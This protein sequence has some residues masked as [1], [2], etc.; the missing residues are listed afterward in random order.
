MIL[1]EKT[2]ETLRSAFEFLLRMDFD[3]SQQRNGVGLNKYDSKIIHD[4]YDEIHEITDELIYKHARKLIKY[5][6]QLVEKAGMDREDLQSAFAAFGYEKKNN[7]MPYVI[8]NN[9]VQLYNKLSDE[10]DKELRE[11][12]RINSELDTLL[13]VDYSRMANPNKIAENY[14]RII[15]ILVEYD[16]PAEWII[17]IFRVYLG[18]EKWSKWEHLPEIVDEIN[19]NKEDKTSG[20]QEQKLQAPSRFSFCVKNYKVTEDGIIKI[21][22]VNDVDYDRQLTPTPFYISSVVENIDKEGS[23]EYKIHIKN[24]MGE[25]I[26]IFKT[27]G[28]LLKRNE[29]L[30]L[31][32]LIHFK[33][34]VAKYIMDYFDESILKYRSVYPVELTA[35]KN[36][37]K[38]DNTKFVI[39]DKIYT[40]DSTRD[41]VNIEEEE[42]KK[43]EIVGDKDEWTE[44]LKDV[45]GEEL[46]RLKMYATVGAFIIRFTPVDTF[47]FHNYAESSGGKT[48][49][50][51]IGASTV[52]NPSKND[53][54]ITSASNTS[55]GIEL[56]L[57]KYTDTP[58]YF[59]ETSANPDFINS[60]YMIGNEKG[61]GRGT[62]ELK[63]KEGGNWKTIVQTTGEEPLTKGMSTKTGDQTRVIEIHDRLPFYEKDY[64]DMIDITLKKNHGLFREEIMQEIFKKKEKFGEEY[65]QVSQ[66]F[67]TCRNEFAGRKKGYFVVLA[68]GGAIIERVLTRNGITPRNNVEICKKYYEKAVVEDPTIPYSDRALQ[69]VYQWT[70]RNLSR[71]ERSKK[72]FG[73]DG[74]VKG[75]YETYGWMTKDSIYYDEGV[76]TK[77]LESTGFNYGRVKDE[78]KKDIIEP[79]KIKGVTKSYVSPSTINGKRIR[80][81]R[82]K[83]NTLTKRLGM[84]G[85]IIEI[86]KNEIEKEPDEM[87]LKE[88][89]TKFLYENSEYNTVAY[90]DEQAAEALIRE[91]DQIELVYGGKSYI[92]DMMA[93]CRRGCRSN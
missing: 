79:F 60:V 1:P 76:L 89:C 20:E 64:L 91:Y 19:V 15:S 57:D 84:E 67:D 59:D 40:K 25:E 45:I 46:V 21:E 13:S 4:D 70:V 7:K 81:I 41:L 90:T 85:P 47:I 30:K 51:R 72:D 58:V 55:T 44:N 33:E 92:V 42:I 68:M 77:E 78:W 52:G 48:L 29:V 8:E 6:N 39:G 24:I 71:F 14:K 36:G 61:K 75:V 87:N 11:V 18:G 93:L 62:K 66:Q 63:Y 65:K 12:V 88:K 43:Y 16:F 37:W 73:E 49:A 3:R 83:I 5:E 38:L 9:L 56:H 22:T 80:G 74:L 69:S 54:M 34:S 31:Q 82:I 10:I 32:D 26:D 53:G 27:P 17:E 50:M 86:P 23:L 2:L 35:V 28:E